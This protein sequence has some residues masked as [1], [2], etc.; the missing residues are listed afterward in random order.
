MNINDWKTSDELAEEW[1]LTSRRVQ[2]MCKEGRLIGAVKKGH[3]WMIPAD[4]KR[5]EKL[6]SGPK[7]K[8]IMVGESK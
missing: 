7:V 5:P 3:Q 6:R 2:I 1:G 8:E 4:V